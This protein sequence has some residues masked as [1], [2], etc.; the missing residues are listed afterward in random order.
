MDAKRDFFRHTL[1][2]LAYR[3][4]RALENAPESFAEYS[5][6]GRTPVQILSH[7]GDLMEWARSMVEGRQGWQNSAPLTWTEEKKRF[8]TVLQALDRALGASDLAQLDAERLFQGPVADAINHVGQIA[9]LRR[10]AGCKMHG[11]NYYVAEIVTGRT[12]E[13]QAAPVRTF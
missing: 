3:A 9:M 10:L 5:G 2:T 8:F 6:A 4:T 12:G 11:E 13:E 7:M 1:A